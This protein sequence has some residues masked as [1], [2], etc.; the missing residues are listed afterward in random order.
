M[1]AREL[2]A[3]PDAGYEPI[4]LLDDD[5]LRVGQVIEG[6]PV[7]GSTAQA[8]ELAREAGAEVLIL[9]MPSAGRARIRTV[10]ARCEA[11]GLPIR[12][13]PGLYELL[14]GNV[15]ITRVRPLRIEDLLGREV[16]GLDD[17]AAVRLR[18][19]FAGRRL[20]VTGAGGSIGS[21]LCR[22]LAKLEPASLVLV[23]NHENH[24][25]EIEQELRPKL[26]ACVIPC[27]V[28]V[29]EVGDVDAVFSEH[30]PEI[31]FHAAA[32]KH[33]PMMEL[34][35]TK[36]VLNNV[37]GTRIVARAARNFGAERFLLVSTD[38][39]VNPTSVMGATKRAAELLVLGMNG[40]ATRYGAVRFGNVLGSNGSVLHTFS[41]QIAVGG[42][43]TLTHP[44]ITRF[45]MTIPE[46]VRLVLEATAGGKG[47]ELFILD[48]GAPVKIID[49]ARQMIRLS[50]FEEGEIGIEVVGLRPGEKLYEELVGTDEEKR[51]SGVPSVWVA[52]PTGSGLDDVAGWIRRLEEAAA[53]G[54]V[55]GT[56]R[57][58]AAG[59]GYR[60]TPH[61][62]PSHHDR[63]QLQTAQ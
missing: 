31:V 11:A 53:T 27:L 4:G 32:F 33:V 15:E 26:G 56:L 8:A 19:A 47:G 49:L 63:P 55:E 1:T 46:A 14:G 36:A 20:L 13:V 3:R 34:H 7:L 39:A 48:M 38:K 51:A 9:T 37:R 5:L 29:R 23:E 17:L 44:E 54:D 35:P 21:E 25:F 6:L 60:H 59:T 18:R 45:F 57:M 2:R 58:L 16:V 41:R 40:G 28:D 43:V 12:T 10:V 24:L 22:Q 61:G 30:R 50:G 52:R 62:G 42:P